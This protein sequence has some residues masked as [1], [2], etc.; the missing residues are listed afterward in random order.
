MKKNKKHIN[1]LNLYIVILTLFI[2][3][4]SY[5]AFDDL[6]YVGISVLIVIFF[7]LFVS[8]RVKKEVIK[9]KQ[10]HILHDFIENFILSLSVFKT[11]LAT[12][13]DVYELSSKSLQNELALVSHLDVL[14][15]LQYLRQFFN[16]RLYD[17]FL[18]TITFYSEQGGDILN[19]SEL[20]LK[21]TQR[22]RAKIIREDKY[23]NSVLINL[24]T[25]WGFVFLIVF[26]LR[27]LLADMYITF[28]N[29]K[30][31]ILGL[32]GFL[33]LFYFSIY[34]FIHLK[35]KPLKKDK[36]NISLNE[37]SE[38][39]TYFRII[40]ETNSNVYTALKTTKNYL[41]NLIYEQFVILISD[42]EFDETVKPFVK[43]S[44]NFTQPLLK[45]ICIMIYQFAKTGGEKAS[46]YEFNYMF[47]EV[48]TI[49]QSEMDETYKRRFESVGLMPMLGT[50][51]IM[52]VMMIGV[53]SQ[54]GGS[55]SV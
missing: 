52:L 6:I 36:K 25:N 7:V 39:F 37:F 53:L 9:V 22:Q 35:Y 51:L 31:F 15:Q 33:G 29:D 47:N 14:E 26:A 30:T 34:N 12:R 8:F 45:H 55:L 2:A 42:I 4:F 27:F 11:L 32:N 20:L 43:F 40:L 16:N 18:S 24:L 49:S 50:G 23:A 17:V 48:A 21:E 38:A 41:E 44:R 46:L 10:K 1:S 54:V 5:F 3:F 19:L 28:L 13:D